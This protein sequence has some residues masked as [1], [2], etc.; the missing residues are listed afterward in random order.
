M[1]ENWN[2]LVKPTDNVF[3]L[4]DF[5]FMQLQPLRE[6]LYNLNGFK[7]LILGNHDK[8]IIENRAKL[9]RD[10]KLFLGIVDYLELDQ[11]VAGD[12]GTKIILAHYGHRVWNKA[13]YGSIH[14]YGH[15][16]G[17]LPPFGRSV[18]VGVDAPF[19]INRYPNGLCA[20]EPNR[21]GMC[22]RKPEDYRP[23]SLDEVTTYMKDRTYEAVD[24]HEKRKT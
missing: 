18:D 23:V 16:H 13:H 1:V 9:T 14:L 24:R 2:S 6:L 20:E 5:A 7:T 21:G 12:K 10:P 8:V 15:S 22:P 17:T 4:G 11:Q 19:I 3:H